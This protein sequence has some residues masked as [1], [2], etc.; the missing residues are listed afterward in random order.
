MVAAD[1]QRLSLR[2]QAAASRA[3]FSYWFSS[4]VA[5]G[6]SGQTS[7]RPIRRRAVTVLNGCAAGGIDAND[8]E[9]VL[10]DVAHRASVSSPR[11]A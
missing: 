11:S 8:A 1:Q 4:G 3:C 5:S 10:V 2:Q 7:V 9:Q 6:R